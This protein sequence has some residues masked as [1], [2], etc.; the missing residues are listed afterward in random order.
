M[1]TKEEIYDEQIAPVLLE[2]GKIAKE[3]GIDL[4]ACVDISDED[5]PYAMAET[6]CIDMAKANAA[7][8]LV[9]FAIRAKGNVDS[10]M[11]GLVKDQRGKPHNSFVL[12]ILERMDDATAGADHG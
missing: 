3:H 1:P 9:Q 11:I 5:D 2:A 7:M 4:L 8:R 12:K 10:L 6:R